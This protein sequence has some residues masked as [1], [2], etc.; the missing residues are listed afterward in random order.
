MHRDKTACTEIS[1][2]LTTL[3]PIVAQSLWAYAG[4]PVKDGLKWVR[5]SGSL[6]GSTRKRD[7]SIVY[8]AQIRVMPFLQKGNPA[9]ATGIY[10][11]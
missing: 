1:Y 10:G 6:F 5:S 3:S 11:Y 4:T 9:R 8:I 7:R 2:D